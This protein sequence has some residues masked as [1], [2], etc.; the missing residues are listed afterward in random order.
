M[1]VAVRTTLPCSIDAAWEALHTP[2]IFREV[3]APFTKFRTDAGSSLPPRFT[4]EADYPV[5]VMAMGLIPIGRQT[6]NLTDH[7]SDW[8]HRSVVDSGRGESGALSALRNWRHEMSLT[9]REDGRVDFSDQLTASAGLLTP[10][11]WCGLQLFWWWR[12]YRLLAITRS[13]DRPITRTWNQ[14]YRAK[15]AMWSGKVNPV[16][17]EVASTLTPGKALDVGCGEGADAIHLAELGWDTLGVEAS[18]VALWRAHREATARRRDSTPR[19][20][21]W[22]VADISQPWSWRSEQFDFVSLQF[23]H[24]DSETRARIWSEALASVAPGGT[25]LIVGHDVS[26]AE[27]GI[28]RPPAEMCFDVNELTR[29]VPSDWSRVDARVRER[30]QLIDGAETTVGDVVLISQR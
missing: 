29:V 20:V 2:D 18:S 30:T 1:K 22:R 7:V 24:T 11:A 23:I 8:A 9:A 28:R 10:F 12:K 26:D 15:S 16:L 14:R 3:S 6:I 25:L 5:T 4:T 13:L 27:K 21:S 17:A 19:S